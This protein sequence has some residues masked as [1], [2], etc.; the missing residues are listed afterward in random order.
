MKLLM[1][2]TD[3]KLFES[4]SNVLDR[5][6]KLS[7][8]YDKLIIV[9]LSL[10]KNSL[11]QFEPNDKLLIIPTNSANR[12]LY[13][14]NAF[15]LGRQLIKREKFE[16]EDEITCQDP[17]EVGLIGY[18]LKKSF[19]LKLEL[20]IHTDLYSPYF[21]SHSILNRIRLIIVRFTLPTAN[22]I[23]VVSGKVA[24]SL[25][26]RGISKNKIEIRPIEVDLSKFTLPISF[27]LKRKYPEFNKII[28]I[29]SRLEKEK[30][31]DLAI[32]AFSEL[33]VIKKDVGLV[34]VGDGRERNS[35]NNKCVELEIQ[36]YVRFEGWQNDLNSYYKGADLLLVTSYYEGYGLVFKEAQACGCKIVSTDVGIAR[37]VGAKIVSRSVIDIA[38][39][40]L[41][42]LK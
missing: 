42:I 8:K 28:L 1:F 11:V 5:M 12:L 31:I 2:S 3:R 30:G 19:N 29:V 33:Q 38:E 39:V 27:S 4:N 14:F 6:I 40:L 35:L 7:S 10:K 15:S 41:N 16:A 25:I 9:V 23:R 13:I 21:A 18:F 26:S 34:I 32:K 24:E 36:D 22:K 20:Q 17:F 37:E